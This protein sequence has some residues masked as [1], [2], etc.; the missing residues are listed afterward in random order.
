[1]ALKERY[2]GATHPSSAATPTPALTAAMPVNTRTAPYTSG[3]GPDVR[4][5]PAPADRTRGTGSASKPIL[6]RRPGRA[7]RRPAMAVA[8]PRPPGSAGPRKF[9][10]HAPPSSSMTTA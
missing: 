9:L 2:H 7:L 6:G 10:G 3:D 4:P 1:V 8:H 5:L